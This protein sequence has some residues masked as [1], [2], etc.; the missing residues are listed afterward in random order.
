MNTSIMRDD[1]GDGK[2]IV[3]VQSINKLIKIKV[4][5]LYPSETH[6]CYK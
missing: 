3:P 5:H 4:A 2:E 6:I 1:D